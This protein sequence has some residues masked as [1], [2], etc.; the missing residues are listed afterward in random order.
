[1]T[2]DPRC[3]KWFSTETKALEKEVKGRL[4]DW[5]SA[6]AIAIQNFS[7]KGNGPDDLQ[8]QWNFPAALLF[9]VTTITAIGYKHDFI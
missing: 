9:V 4:D 6:V 5:H 3:C 8:A 1:L 2:R 7:Y